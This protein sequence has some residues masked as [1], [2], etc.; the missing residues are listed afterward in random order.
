MAPP[1]VNRT[2]EKN[3]FCELLTSR[4]KPIVLIWGKNGIGKTTLL[5]W[6]ADQCVSNQ[7]VKVELLWGRSRKYSP[8]GVMRRIRDEL[9]SP[10]HFNYFTELLNYYT[11]PGAAPSQTLKVIIEGDMSVAEKAEFID[12]SVRDVAGVIIHDLRV[13][14]PRSDIQVPPE[15]RL[16]RLT[17][18]FIASLA[19][20]TEQKPC[21]LFLDVDSNKKIFSPET[22]SWLWDDLFGAII[23]NKLPNVRAVMCVAP[24]PNPDGRYLAY[25]EDTALKHFDEEHVEEYMIQCGLDERLGV[26]EKER[27]AMLNVIMSET[28]GFPLGVVRRVDGVV[29]W[30][31]KKKRAG[32]G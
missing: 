31:K 4:E 13:E 7:M 25:L 29:K 1:F 6:M 24:K 22:R 15:E 30:L 26:D 5:E 18:L 3:R 27:K 21:W 11:D 17:E 28:D 2:E 8:P 9:G 10:A 14:A 20:T 23:R 16:I 19:A 32:R 12:S